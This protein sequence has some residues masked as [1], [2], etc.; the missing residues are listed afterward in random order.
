ML[1]PLGWGVKY[2]WD[3]VLVAVDVGAVSKNGSSDLTN[4][5]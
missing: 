3:G 4:G 1:V 5:L 2:L